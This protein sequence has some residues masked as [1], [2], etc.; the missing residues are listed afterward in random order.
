MATP[1]SQQIGIWIIAIVLLVGT[2]GSFF[3]MILG[4]QNQAKDQASLQ[5]AYTEYQSDLAAQTKQLS[6]RYYANFAKYSTVPV[7]FASDDIKTV[8]TNDLQVGDGETITPKSEYSAYY[9]GWNPKGVVFDQS[10]DH[11]ALKAPIAGGNL[12]EGWNEGVIGMKLGGVRQI[13][14]PSAKAYGANGHGDNIPPNTP[15]KFI[16]MA[17]PKVASVPM[18]Q[19]L[20]D[21]YQSQQ[22][23]QQ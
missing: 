20:L 12:I 14:I 17:I 9:I 22:N 5:K 23:G 3:V 4:S 13:T 15:L 10:I 2:L 11:G 8:T 16:V 6:D 19:V 1:R 21:Y 18:P 7:A